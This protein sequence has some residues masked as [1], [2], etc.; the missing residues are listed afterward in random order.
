MSY[1]SKAE[2][3]EAKAKQILEKIASINNFLKDNRIYGFNRK[4]DAT[5]PEVREPNPLQERLLNAWDNPRY[6]VFTYTGANRI[7]KTTIG[8]IIAFA[9]MFGEWPWSGRKFRFIHTKPRRVLY[10]G[11]GW[12]THIKLVLMPKFNEWWPKN[13]AL[14][15]K[16]N[17]QG[18]DAVWVDERTKSNLT[19]MSNNQDSKE[20]EG[21][22][23]DLIIYDEPPKRDIRVACSRGLIDR[24]GK[25]L[26][27][28][29]LL[30][31]AWVKREVISAR[32]PDGSPDPTIFNINGEIDS[33]VGYGLTQ[34]GVDQFVKTLKPHEVEAR[35]KG[36]PS[37]MSNLVC[38]EFD[39]SKHVKD[40]FKVPLDWLVDINIDF[41]PS[42]PWAIQFMATARNNI[43][44]IVEEIEEKGNPKYIG[45]QIVRKIKEGNYR[46]N[47]P[48]QID[49]LSKGDSN[50]DETVFKILS[51]TLAAYGYSL[52]V[53]SKD[54]DNG[55]A[56]LNNLI[57]TENE[58]PGLYFFRDCVKSIEQIEN[59]MYDK[60]TLKPEKK[61]DDFCEVTYRNCLKNT[62]WYEE[63]QGNYAGKSVVL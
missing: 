1:I 19:V 47:N 54:K 42:K 12:E 20:F 38:P 28:M 16:K 2:Q 23:Y 53:A 5:Y 26:F 45:E 43:K 57:W 34:E 58:M 17:N 4:R 13:R 49:P 36:K 24:Q 50:N 30:S 25:E 60:D 48:V 52:D 15:T 37:F 27:C 11:Q 51:D 63:Y 40:R 32:L 21:G 55:I 31:E 39:V 14:S 22:D 9:T 41:H 35:I 8:T 33:N 56:L 3:E 18:V 10:V 29:T 44:Y 46:V 6:K 59:W 61:E 62:Q 7:G